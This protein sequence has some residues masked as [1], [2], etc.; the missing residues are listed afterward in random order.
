MH[1]LSER[2]E[3]LL[4]QE[5]DGQFLTFGGFVIGIAWLFSFASQLYGRVWEPQGLIV[6]QW[7]AIGALF[8]PYVAIYS[9][10][11]NVLCRWLR[12]LL[13][14]VREEAATRAP[15]AVGGVLRWTE[16]LMPDTFRSVARESGRW[17]RFVRPS[18]SLAQSYTSRATRFLRP[19]AFLIR[20]HAW[21][22]IGVAARVLLV[23]CFLACVAWLIIVDHRRIAIVLGILQTLTFRRLAPRHCAGFMRVV[24]L[25]TV[26]IGAWALAIGF[27]FTPL[28]EWLLAATKTTGFGPIAFAVSFVLVVLEFSIFET[29]ARASTHFARA[30]IFGAAIA[31]FAEFGL[32]TD[33]LLTDW[34]PY[35][36]TFWVAPAQFI[37][38]GA[39]PLW[40]Y[41]SQYGVLSELSIAFWPSHS[42]WQALYL[43]IAIALGATSI[44]IF[45]LLRHMR[46]GAANAIFALV[47]TCAIVYSAQG[48]RYPA[49]WR[50]YPQLGLRFQ[51]IIA[52]FIVAYFIR[53]NRHRP[54]A[55]RWAYAAGHTIWA[56]SFAWSFE[57][58][59]FTSCAWCAFLACDLL[60]EV[61]QHR[62]RL[63]AHLFRTLAPLIIIP[64]SLYIATEVVF[65]I[66]RKHGPD[67]LSYLEF[68][69]AY[70]R[71]GSGIL[72]ELP[73]VHGSL[74]MLL[75]VLIGVGSVAVAL[76]RQRRYGCLPVVAACWFGLWGTSAYYV[77]E[78]WE[79]HAEGLAPV[80]V[81]AVAVILALQRSERG[82]SFIS[83]PVRAAFTPIF[84]LLIAYAY[85]EP[86]HIAVIRAPLMP[87]FSLDS[88]ADFPAITGELAGLFVRAGVRPRDRVILPIPYLANK[89]Q[90]G[91]ILP[92]MRGRDGRLQ[93]QSAWL[94][95]SPIG[96]FNALF[97]LSYERRQTY[98]RRY[99]DDVHRTGWFA[100]YHRR[101]E[102]RMLL[103]DLMNLQITRS[104]NYEIARCGVE[105]ASRS[106]GDK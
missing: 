102:C 92:F 77:G 63:A 85:G 46:S 33:N 71:Q 62:D 16:A 81:S 88:T 26:S 79:V 100:T 76:I 52:I 105:P 49:G 28:D 82:P 51:W 34:L 93:E 20:R 72:Q 31:A 60:V 18:G 84:V 50:L 54:I 8:V 27:T 56:F 7:L 58:G 30:A 65:R 69:A 44:A 1:E 97:T 96:P 32:R 90:L 48:A 23:G 3:L 39:W 29:K 98:L 73:N 70:N 41:P 86:G 42:P 95:M 57:S 37:R 17:V 103:P 53:C 22:A 89:L 55:R 5:R 80:F 38:N 9:V 19:A 87:G 10:N 67:W 74:W 12:S 91:M 66:A 25:L 59:I 47:A 15:A 14:S 43:E 21:Q 99:L 40:D 36:R 75:L 2:E 13:H 61:S 106:R 11:P 6:R 35:H 45:A 101:A 68:S 64:I 4:P 24:T 83:L 94:P 78:T 104:T